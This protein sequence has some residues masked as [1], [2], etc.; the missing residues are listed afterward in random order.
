MKFPEFNRI[1]NPND[2]KCYVAFT[3]KG[4]PKALSFDEITKISKTDP[5]LEIGWIMPKGFFVIETDCMNIM[6]SIIARNEEVMVVS[7]GKKLQI[8]LSHKQNQK[9]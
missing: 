9:Y 2:E 4:S 5:T 1:V 8:C 3:N 6:P 7:D